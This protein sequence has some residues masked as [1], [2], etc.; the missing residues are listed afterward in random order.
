[1]ISLGTEDAELLVRVPRSLRALNGIPE[2]EQA[3]ARERAAVLASEA[4]ADVLLPGGVRTSP[5]G[6]GWS[7]DIDVH[8]VD[9]PEPSELMALGWIPLDTLLHRLGIPSKGRW[10]VVENGRVLA[11]LDLQ[12]GP[13]S[14]P[15]ASLLSRCRRRGEVRAREVLEARALLRAG[16]ALPSDDPVIGL[17]ARV[18]AGLGGRAL[19]RWR[20]GPALGAPAPLPGRRFRRLWASGRSALRPRLLVAVSGV[21]GSGKS[22]LSQLVALN[23]ERASVPV[24]RV[25]A[26]PGSIGAGLLDGLARAVKKGLRQDPSWGSTQVAKGLPSGEMASRRGLVGWAWT[27]LLTLYFLANV[28]QQHVRRHGVLLYDRHLLDAL[29]HLDFVYEGVDLRLHR[30]IVRRGMPK[31]QLYVYLDVPAEVA[32]R[33]KPEMPEDPGAIY[34]GEYAIRRQLENYESRSGEIEHLRRLDGNR[35]AHELAAIVTQWVAEL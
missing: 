15:V 17:A 27:M 34:S 7:G 11:P 8:L 10:A 24:G 16:H 3:V 5:L 20:D 13:P 14:D 21:D 31:P 18:E 9:W 32:L 4:L 6:P 33:R 22:T 2:P 26:R 35:P 23:L 19:A 1:M 28:R 29:V 12:L 30:A 25:W